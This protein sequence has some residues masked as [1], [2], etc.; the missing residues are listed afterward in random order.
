ME[1]KKG[2]HVPELPALPDNQP[3]PKLCAYC[4]MDEADPDH[5]C[6]SCEPDP[7]K[8]PDLQ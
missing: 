6:Y 7:D 1:A 8:R 3:A 2:A 4:G 5:H